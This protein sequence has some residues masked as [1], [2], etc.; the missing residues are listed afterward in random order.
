MPCCLPVAATPLGLACSTSSR[1]LSGLKRSKNFAFPPFRRYNHNVVVTWLM[2]VVQGSVRYKD[3][4]SS[5][6]SEDLVVE[7]ERRRRPHTAR[8]ASSM[9]ISAVRSTDVCDELYVARLASLGACLGVVRGKFRGL[10]VRC[11]S[12]DRCI[13]VGPVGLPT[14]GGRCAQWLTRAAGLCAFERGAQLG[15][16]GPGEFLVFFFSV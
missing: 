3:D 8:C 1:W 12:A 4:G 13:G 2:T 10:G 11:C 7:H 5:V 9:P 15:A 16:L 6:A 14:V